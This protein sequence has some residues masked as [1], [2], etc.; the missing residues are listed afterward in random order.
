MHTFRDGTTTEYKTMC[1]AVQA[2][3][4][5]FPDIKHDVAQANRDTQPLISKVRKVCSNCGCMRAT[6][7]HI[8]VLTLLIT[9]NERC[10]RSPKC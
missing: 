7:S 6:H 2:L 10:T 3:F 9:G 5:H 4:R 1:R 8:Q